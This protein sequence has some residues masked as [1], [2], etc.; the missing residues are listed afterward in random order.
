MLREC[1]QNLLLAHDLDLLVRF[2]DVRLGHD[3]ESHRLLFRAIYECMH[4]DNF[5]KRSFTQYTSHLDIIQCE[6]AALD[7]TLLSY[8]YTLG[9]T[10]ALW[11]AAAFYPHK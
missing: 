8:I 11:L 5:S 1:H 9:I 4:H 2:N 3:F 6:S 7:A 10:Q